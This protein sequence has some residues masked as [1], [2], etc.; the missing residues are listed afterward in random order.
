MLGYRMNWPRVTARA[1]STH[2]RPTISPEPGLSGVGVVPSRARTVLSFFGQQ[3]IRNQWENNFLM[4]QRRLPTPVSRVKYLDG[5][6]GLAAMQV[7]IHHYTLAFLND[8]NL[9]GF[10]RNGNFAVYIFFLIS[11]F[12]LTFSF[13]KDPLG[14][15]HNLAR[16]LIRL[17]LPI[18]AAAL[19]ATSLLWMMH[20]FGKQ[21]AAISGSQSLFEY[22]I[23]PSLWDVV[24]ETSGLRMLTGFYDTTIFRGAAHY[25][26]TIIHTVDPPMWTLHIELWGSILVMLLVYFRTKAASLYPW[27]VLLMLLVTGVHPLNLFG[28]GHLVATHL[29]RIPK[30]LLHSRLSLIIGSLAFAFGIYLAATA[31]PPA[32]W[33]FTSL[34][35]LSV[36]HQPPLILKDEVG[37][38]MVFIAIMFIAPVRHVLQFKTLV[39]L[40]KMSFSL[41][42]VHYPI[43]VTIGSIIFVSVA[44]HIDVTG[45]AAVSFCVGIMITMTV[46]FFFEKYV[47]HPAILLSR[48]VVAPLQLNTT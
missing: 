11:G 25:L 43:I 40:G 37:A 21:A 20:R 18:A 33:R 9:L 42:L 17:G 29:D 3:I 48:R 16:R 26:P 13:E 39:W 7:V 30:R 24:A 32:I 12:V 5:L 45:A 2:G 31:D 36:F 8:N 44:Y 10:V 35:N 15:S 28:V 34:L 6:R 23:F 46:A 38:V 14:V 4:T 41:Y 1:G 22:S 47:D 19:F 27:I